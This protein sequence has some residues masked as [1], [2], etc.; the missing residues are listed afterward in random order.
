MIDSLT[1]Q[2]HLEQKSL[3]STSISINLIP[4]LTLLPFV[5]SSLD[6]DDC[7]SDPCGSNGACIDLESSYKCICDPGYTGSDCHSVCDDEHCF[8]NGTCTLCDGGICK[9]TG[10]P[11]TCSCPS[12]LYGA[13]CTDRK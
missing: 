1:L 11:Y 12:D 2:C 10:L 5:C 4:K 13:L 7:S 8:N 6:I 9:E 3:K